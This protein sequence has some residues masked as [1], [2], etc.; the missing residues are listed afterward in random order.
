M[1]TNKA[2]V[3]LFCVLFS[4]VVGEHGMEQEIDS[5]LVEKL[6]SILGSNRL[7]FETFVSKGKVP[8]EIDEEGPRK[9]ID[10]QI[11]GYLKRISENKFSEIYTII[12]A[13]GSGKTH[14]YWA[15]YNQSQKLLQ[16]KQQGTLELEECY[17]R[18]VY[19]PSPPSASRIILHIYTCIIN[20]IGMEVIDNVS[21]KLVERWGG[22]KRIFVQTDYNEIISHGIQEN[23]GILSDCVKAMVYYQLDSKRKDAAKKWLLGTNV[24]TEEMEKMEIKETVES[25][26]ICLSMLT[27]IMKSLNFPVLLYFDE[28]ESPF[29][30]FGATAERKFL[31]IIRKLFN[32]VPNVLIVLSILKEIWTRIREV[33]KE[34]LEDRIKEVVELK[35][36]TLADLKMF[37]AKSM[38]KFWESHGIKYPYEGAP[39]LFPLNEE[40]FKLIIEKTGGNQRTCI[41]TLKQIMQDNIHENISIDD[42]IEEIKAQ[43]KDQK[44]LIVSQPKEK[45][46]IDVNQNQEPLSDEDITLQVNPASIVGAMMKSIE[47]SAKDQKMAIQLFFDQK[48]LIGKKSTMIAGVI[49]FKEKYYGIETPTIINFDKPSEMQVFYGLK[50]IKEA[51]QDKIIEKAVFI[52]PPFE[53]TEKIKTILEDLKT[54]LFLIEFSEP[55]AE[56]LIRNAMSSPLSITK[57]AAKFLFE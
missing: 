46:D 4:F 26:D 10:K 40:V 57:E 11:Y 12:G 27:L 5:E 32:E 15:Y 34:S 20:D 21:K 17:W 56:S 37:Y 13:S 53:R 54:K 23:P 2:R 22:K 9:E 18:I 38:K 28:V 49:K 47:I 55:Q 25:E 7:P 14:A 36:F 43:I 33:L 19:I 24:K 39:P 1:L 35:P 16:K 8:E 51:I 52:S 50:R 30:M 29:R 45:N 3:F 48:F 44:A 41:K 42:L 6:N 31:E